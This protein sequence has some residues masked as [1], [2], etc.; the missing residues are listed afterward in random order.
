MANG[1]WSLPGP[2][3]ASD[4]LGVSAAPR[5]GLRAGHSPRVRGTVGIPSHPVALSPWLLDSDSRWV[6][7]RIRLQFHESWGLDLG[8][9]QG[10]DHP[11]LLL[12][13]HLPGSKAPSPLAWLPPDTWSTC[14][15]ASSWPRACCCQLCSGHWVGGW[16]WF[17]PRG[18]GQKEM[19]T[20]LLGKVVRG[21]GGRQ[22]G[23]VSN[24]FQSL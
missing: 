1:L 9:T 10:S 22:R 11:S 14:C 13:P 5:L 18:Q 8:G 19:V 12:L 6:R 3:E 23:E 20:A 24:L 2:L 21:R 7:Y 17:G 4:S 15:V 16:V